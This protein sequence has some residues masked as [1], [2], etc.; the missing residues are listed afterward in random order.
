MM[1]SKGHCGW[2]VVKVFA[3]LSGD[4][5][6]THTYLFLR[7]VL[8]F[9]ISVLENMNVFNFKKRAYFGFVCL[10]CLKADAHMV[11]CGAAAV[12]YLPARGSLQLRFRIWAKPP[13]TPLIRVRD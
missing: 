6:L 7:F 13:V 9:K 1:M 5:V 8:I 2:G 10:D 3:S 12:G 4:C 11:I